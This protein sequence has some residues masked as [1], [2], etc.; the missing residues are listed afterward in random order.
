[1]PPLRRHQLV[2]LTDEGWCRQRERPWDADV[3]A[4][5]MHWADRR[6]PL[7]VTRQ[8]PGGSDG[9]RGCDDPLTLGLPA[10]LRWQ[11]RR[12]ALRVE[13]RDVAWLDEFPRAEKLVP[14][15]PWRCRESWRRL[16]GALVALGA[17]T[18]AYGSHGWQ[19]IS[20]L[21]HV[22]PQSD[23]DLWASVDSVRHADAVAAELERTVMPDAPRLDG[24][25]IF[26][27]G[28]AV[29]WREWRAWRAGR[30]RAVLVKTL[31]GA[32]LVEAPV[33]GPARTWPA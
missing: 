18:R 14:L 27:D 22:H 20:E 26:P 2:Q 12:I 32:T 29:A 31:T 13:R 21:D 11:R 3:Q 28:R 15:L 10:P 24:E 23:I 1:M 7:V 8:A 6:L 33:A 19:L 25:L 16:C 30:C 5:L 17:T 4:C 9:D